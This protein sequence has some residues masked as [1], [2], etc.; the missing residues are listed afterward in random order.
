MVPVPPGERAMT[1]RK[2]RKGQKP[3][4]PRVKRI[5]ESDVPDAIAKM[6]HGGP[7]VVATVRLKGARR[8]K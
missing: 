6:K 3:K 1:D 5:N 4:P 2:K 8:G 7:R